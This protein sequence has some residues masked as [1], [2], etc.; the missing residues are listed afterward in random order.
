[1]N[2]SSE[3]NETKKGLTPEQQNNV[4]YNKY[5]K[6]YLET[7]NR[8]SNQIET[9]SDNGYSVREDDKANG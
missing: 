9:I 6:N 3:N 4:L 5:W 2:T 1:M 7:I 8:W